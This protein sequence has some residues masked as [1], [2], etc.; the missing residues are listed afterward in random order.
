MSKVALAMKQ[1]RSPE[2]V[3]GRF[4]VRRTIRSATLWAAIFGAYVASKSAGYASAYPSLPSREKLAD[5]FSS[6]IGLS[7]L[8][9]APHKIETVAGFTVWNTLSVM[10]I[11]GAIWGLLLVTKSLRGEQDAGRWELLLTGPTT[12]RKATTNAL[13]GLAVSLLTLYVVVAIAFILVGAIHTVNFGAQ[14]ALFFALAA[15]SG[16]AEFVAIGALASQIMPTRSRAASLATVIFGASFLVRAM[17]D[18]TSAHWLLV[19][20]P[21]GWIEKLQPL[22]GSQPLWLIPILLL[23]VVCSIGA[24]VLAG[25]HDL[26][27][28]TIA[29]KDTARPH[30]KLLGRPIMIALRLTRVS[31]LSWLLAVAFVST[32]FGVLT[33]SAAQALSQSTSAGHL[34]SRLGIAQNNTLFGVNTYLSIV[35]FLLMPIVMSYAASALGRVREDEAEGYLDNLLVRPVGRLQWLWGRLALASVVVLC[36]GLLGALCTWLGASS[37]ESGITFH[38]MLLSGINVMVPALCILGLGVFAFG[39]MPRA[40]T[41]IA[42]GIIGWSFLIQMISSGLNLNHWILDTSVLHHMALTPVS[43]PDWTSVVVIV[44][45]S[46]VAALLGAMRFAKRDIVTA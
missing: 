38:S 35:F 43:N 21:L 6:N 22:Y 25:R 23:I 34:L 17:A 27:A 32:F 3:I 1:F 14:P 26:G 45:V 5:S 15:I 11:I 31:S 9:G 16:A 4:M 41:V 44:L 39:Y 28:S 40:T 7:A 33:K 19:V 46:V 24:V 13:I 10:T 8:L 30:T 42:Y 18:V 20:T 37:Q 29:D 36:A 12:T 2:T